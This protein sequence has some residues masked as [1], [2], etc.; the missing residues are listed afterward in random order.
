MT[1]ND[2][3]EYEPALAAALASMIEARLGP[4]FDLDDV[5]DVLGKDRRAIHA[6]GSSERF[7]SAMLATAAAVRSMP[8]HFERLRRASGVVAC[9]TVGPAVSALAAVKTV[10]AMLR[11][12]APEDVAIICGACIDPALSTYV[13]VTLWTK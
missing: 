4:G 2:L 13:K 8:A 7:E 1:S 5:R 3:S 6:S 12:E 11:V 9:V 10:A